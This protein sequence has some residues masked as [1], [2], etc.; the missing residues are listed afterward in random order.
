MTPENQ[1]QP[2]LIEEELYRLGKCNVCGEYPLLNSVKPEIAQIFAEL[3]QQRVD[4][5]G[6]QPCKHAQFTITK[7]TR[8][9]T[10]P[11]TRFTPENINDRDLLQEIV[12]LK[13]DVAWMEDAI[14]VLQDRLRD[15]ERRI[16]VSDLSPEQIIILYTFYSPS[17]QTETDLPPEA[18]TYSQPLVS[19]TT[20]NR[21]PDNLRPLKEQI[22]INPVPLATPRIITRDNR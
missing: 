3:H 17:E 18:E 10:Q 22:N 1:R 5:H 16:N 12:R 7:V 2:N 6:N 8:P 9:Q 15:S 21:P 11:P 19:N 14:E 4:E 13:E 20:P